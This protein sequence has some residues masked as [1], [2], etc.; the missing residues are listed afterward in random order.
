MQKKSIR[1]IHLYPVNNK[2]NINLIDIDD[3]ELNIK[4][5][6]K[7]QS[8]YKYFYS[9]N[10][11][12]NDSIIF[13]T[14]IINNEIANFIHNV[15]KDID[16]WIF[17]DN[18]FMLKEDGVKYLTV[19]PIDNIDCNI[20]PNNIV[21]KKLYS[22]INHQIKIDQLVYFFHTDQKAK[23]EKLQKYL[24][25][26]SNLKIKLF[27]SKEYAHPQNLGFLTEED[28]KDLLCESKFYL[29]DNSKYYL[30]EALL[31][32]CLPIN[33]DSSTSIEEQMINN[34]GIKESNNSNIYYCDFVK[35]LLN[36]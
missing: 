6:S 7:D 26:S 17:I 19:E 16:I 25:P 35:R 28:K 27:D 32:G 31:C 18:K 21:N 14:S 29:Y 24:Y 13:N 20:L 22:N 3:S 8:I 34:K 2:F 36:E 23:F 33:I 5:I 12:S 10:I 15:K 11:S 30:H 1:N 9:N 4:I